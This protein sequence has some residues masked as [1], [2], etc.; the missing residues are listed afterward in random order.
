MTTDREVGRDG[1]VKDGTSLKIEL[2]IVGVDASGWGW[3][4]FD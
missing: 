2:F 3:C 1:V 4:V